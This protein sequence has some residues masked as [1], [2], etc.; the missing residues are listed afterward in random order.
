MPLCQKMKCGV[1]GYSKFPAC[2]VSAPP[3]HEVHA[4]CIGPW[5]IALHGG[6]KYQFDVL[7]SID[8]TMNLLEIEE[9]PRKTAQACPDAFES[10][11]LV[12]YPCPAWCIHDQGPKFLGAEFHQLLSQ[13]GIKSVPTSAQNPTGNSIVEAVHKSVG[14]VLRM[15]IHLHSPQTCV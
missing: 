2:S 10:G 4:D 5:M 8:P 12:H 15:L 11:W 1:H 9:L 13:A 6:C 14:A 7:T 3:W